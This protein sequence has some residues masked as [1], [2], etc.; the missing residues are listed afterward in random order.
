VKKS[1]GELKDRSR[2]RVA[3]KLRQVIAE[4]DGSARSVREILRGLVAANDLDLDVGPFVRE[5]GKRARHVQDLDHPR[6]GK[7]AV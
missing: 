7:V 1:Y 6:R 3:E 2:Q 5:L 4:Y